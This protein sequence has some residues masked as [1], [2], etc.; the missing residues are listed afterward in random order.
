MIFRFLV[1]LGFGAR[2]LFAAEGY[3]T[4]GDEHLAA[5]IEQALRENPSVREAFNR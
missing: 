4:L 3:A 2:I 5:Y 1:L